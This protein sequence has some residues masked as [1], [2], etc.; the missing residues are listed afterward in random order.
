MILETSLIATSSL[1]PRLAAVIHTSG[2]LDL[3]SSHIADVSFVKTFQDWKI[4]SR[5]H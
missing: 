5:L 3:P 1:Q 4:S 2:A